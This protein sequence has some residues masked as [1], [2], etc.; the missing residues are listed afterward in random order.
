MR[1]ACQPKINTD[2]AGHNSGTRGDGDGDGGGG[3]GTGDG[4]RG[5]GDGGRG[6]GMGT[7]NGGWV[8]GGRVDGGRGRGRDAWVMGKAFAKHKT[9]SERSGSGWQIVFLQR[10]CLVFRT[11][12]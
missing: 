11:Y 8:D 6:M 7:G 12:E 9:L 4:R 2:S 5:M 1:H 3:R 10:L